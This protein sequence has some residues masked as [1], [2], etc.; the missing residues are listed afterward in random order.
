VES[1]TY[2]CADYASGGLWIATVFPVTI[3]SF[4]P[5]Q[6][7]GVFKRQGH[8]FGQAEKSAA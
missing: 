7:S 6:L 2:I 8:I 4:K 3:G 1:K 5:G